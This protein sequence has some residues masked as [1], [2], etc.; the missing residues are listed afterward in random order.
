[1][2]VLIGNFLENGEELQLIVEIQK[3]K[4]SMINK[5][6]LI[7]LRIYILRKPEMNGEIVINLKKS[8]ENFFPLKLIM[9]MKIRV[10]SKLLKFRHH[11]NLIV[12]FKN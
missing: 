9:G 7:S 2:V 4:I 8:L 11:Q 3:S 6:Q 1:M 5:R 12:V 10:H